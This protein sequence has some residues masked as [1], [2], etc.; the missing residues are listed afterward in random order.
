MKALRRPAGGLIG[1]ALP[2]LPA[3]LTMF[4]L[5]VPLGFELAVTAE[6]KKGPPD[7]AAALARVERGQ[8]A[9]QV[10][11]MLGAPPR[12]IARQIL[13]HRYREQ[14]IYDQP[15]FVRLEFDCPRG[16]KPQLIFIQKLAPGQP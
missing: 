1:R 15:Y 9:E 10:R 11:E 13:Y 14:W 3:R 4:L 7:P 8:T 12:R 2:E 6:D 16:Q 5:L